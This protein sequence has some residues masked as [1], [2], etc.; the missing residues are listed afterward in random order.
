MSFINA[1]FI[2]SAQRNSLICSADGIVNYLLVR[3]GSDLMTRYRC[4][5]AADA[6]KARQL[7]NKYTGM[8]QRI[9]AHIA[10]RSH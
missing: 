7:M 4:W 3:M 9:D 2:L 5:R 6:A 1:N 8:D 10:A